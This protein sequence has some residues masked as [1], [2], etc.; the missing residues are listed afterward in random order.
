M[1]APTGTGPDIDP[2]VRG[3]LAMERARKL[4]AEQQTQLNLAALNDVYSGMDLDVINDFVDVARAGAEGDTSVHVPNQPQN[5]LMLE[6]FI[7]DL[8]NISQ[9]NYGGVHTELGQRLLDPITTATTSAER[10]RRERSVL[11]LGSAYARGVFDVL[12]V[13]DMPVNDAEQGEA[14]AMYSRVT[15]HQKEAIN[16]ILSS[17]TRDLEARKLVPRWD[18]ASVAALRLRPDKAKDNRNVRLATAAVGIMEQAT[19]RLATHYIAARNLEPQLTSPEEGQLTQAQTLERWRMTHRQRVIA[20]IG[21]G[22]TMLTGLVASGTAENVAYGGLI[23]GSLVAIA[24]AVG[25]H[26]RATADYEVQQLEREEHAQLQSLHLTINGRL[27]LARSGSNAV[28]TA[29]DE[30]LMAQ[31]AK[32]IASEMEGLRLLEA[33]YPSRLGA[34]SLIRLPDSSPDE[35]EL[36]QAAELANRR[37]N[38]VMVAGGTLLLTLMLGGVDKAAGGGDASDVPNPATGGEAPVTVSPPSTSVEQ[39]TEEDCNIL[40]ATSTTVVINGVLTDCP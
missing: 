13:T 38:R 5:R 35:V 9:G 28:L 36:P 39:G 3:A 15:T 34:N 21:T 19:A 20:A 10:G 33:L 22:T 6:W 31:T 11:L 25:L 29:H 26:S 2:G 30:G 40:G 18:N 24:G 32:R 37:K 7:D 14:R 27:A 16:G 1:T 4:E 12:L 17:V 8:D 23:S